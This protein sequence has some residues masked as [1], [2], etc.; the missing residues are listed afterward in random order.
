METLCDEDTETASLDEFPVIT[1]KL[2]DE[3]LGKNTK[4]AFRR[5]RIYLCAKSLLQHSLTMELGAQM[6][7]L[8]YKILMLQFITKVCDVFKAKK[9]CDMSLM[10]QA[11]AKIARRID[12]LKKLMDEE[13]K[14]ETIDGHLNEMFITATHNA[15][16]MIKELRKKVNTQVDKLQSEDEKNAM[17]SPLIALNF[18]E[19]VNQKVKRLRE[20]LDKR[21]TESV[22]SENYPKKGST[23]SR[24]DF[25]HYSSVPDNYFTQNNTIEKN[26]RL[27]D[28][29]NWVLY[30]L[31]L[32]ERRVDADLIRKNAF[33][34]ATVAESTYKN[35]QLAISRMI[36]VRLKL[37]AILDNIACEKFPLLLKYHSGI[38]PNII[39]TLLL[40]QYIDMKIADQLEE[41]FEKR[42][43]IATGPS[44]IEEKKASAD[45]FAAAFAAQ[46]DEMIRSRN[47][48]LNEVERNIK[49]LQS[50]WITA[51]NRVSMLR[52]AMKGQSH[53]RTITRKGTVSCQN[54][55]FC[56][57]KKQVKKA[58]LNQYV[59]RLPEKEYQQ[60]AIIFEQH[61]PDKIA[62]LR[63]VLYNFAEYCSGK[64]EKIK[65]QIEEHTVKA[66]KPWKGRR[67]KARA[68]DLAQDEPETDSVNF[69][70]LFKC[71][72]M[73]RLG[74]T[75]F[76]PKTSLHVDKP[77]E[78]FI[79]ENN[80]D[81]TYHV[82]QHYMP[83]PI[84][85]NSVKSRCTLKAEPGTDFEKLQWM[86]DD[87]S[88]TENQVLAAQSTCPDGLSLSEF[89]SF[90]CLRADGYCLQLRKLYGLIETEALPFEQSSVLSLIMQALWECKEKGEAG[91]ARETYANLNDS[92][93]ASSIIQLLKKFIKQ[94]KDNWV[95]PLKLVM[96]SFIVVRV[97]EINEYDFVA[98]EIAE[99]LAEIRITAID[100]IKKIQEAIRDLK[101]PDQSMEQSLRLKLVLVAFAGAI[102]FSVHPS[103]KFHKKILQ[104][105]PYNNYSAS[106]IWLQFVITL[107]NNILLSQDSEIKS[108]LNM[109]MF[110]RLTQRIGVQLEAG[111]KNLVDDNDLLAIIRNQWKN[112]DESTFQCSYFDSDCPQTYCAEINGKIV[113]IDI[114]TGDFLVNNLPVARLPRKISDDPLYYRV[115]QNFTFEIQ[116]EDANTY[117]T[118]QKYNKCVYKFSC[119]NEGIVITECNQENKNELELLPLN[120][121]VDELP[122]LL[123]ENYSHWW[124]KSKNTIDF[125]PKR[126]KNEK[127]SIE[128]GVEYRLD[129]NE[130]CLTHLRTKRNVLDVTSTS[131]LNIVK[132]LSR[133][134]HS[135]F[136]NIL[137]DISV[138]HA[139]I[140]LPRMNLKFR[141]KIQNDQDKEYDIL[142][143]EFRNMRVSLHQKCGTLFGLNHGL[144]LESANGNHS[145]PKLLLMPHGEV[146]VGRD[147]N[148][149]TVDID[150]SEDLFNP[151]F[152]LYSID[153]TC[154]QLKAV[155]NSYSAWIYLAYL[156]ALTSHGEIEPFTGLSGTENAL[157]ILQSGFVWSST[158]YD[159]E[160]IQ[161]LKDFIE[162]S[163]K[164][165]AGGVLQRVEWPDFIPPH[166][167]QDSY[168]FIAKKLLEDSQRLHQLHFAKDIT[169][170]L[171]TDLNLNKRAYLRHLQSSPN[172]RVAETFI[173]HEPIYTTMPEI[174]NIQLSTRT[175]TI[176]S[177]YYTHG[178][179][180][181]LDSKQCEVDGF[182]LWTFL[183][184]DTKTLLGLAYY[185]ELQNILSHRSI[186]KL[187]NMW[188]SLYEA[189]RRKL[190]S[191]EE[192][193]LIWTLLAHKFQDIRPILTLQA[194]ERNADVFEDIESPE[195]DEYKI[196]EGFY[197]KEKIIEILRKHANVGYFYPMSGKDELITKIA[198][199]IDEAW[200]CDRFESDEV[201]DISYSYLYNFYSAFEEINEK[202]MIW[203]QNEMLKDFIENVK[204]KLM[205]LMPEMTTVHAP[206]LT[207]YY[208]PVAK[209]WKKYEIN[210][211][212]KM[213]RIPNK[214]AKEIKEARLL[215]REQ[216][217]KSKKTSEQW[218]KIY[219]SI[220]NTQIEK[221]YIDAGMQP[222]LVLSFVLP[223]LTSTDIDERL[224][225]I[226]GALA[227]AIA[228]EQRQNRIKA[229]T[230]QEQLKPDLDKEEENQPYINWKPC[231]YPEWLIFEIEQNLTIRRIQIEI[232]KR[233]IQPPKTHDA[234]HSTMQLNMG[235]GKTAVLVPILA[236]VLAN[237][238]QLC[239]IT[240]LKSLFATNVK[241]IRKY[242]GG[243]LNRRIYIFPCRRDLPIADHL[244]R[245]LDI[246]EECKELKGS[247]TLLFYQTIYFKFILNFHSFFRS[248]Y[249]ATRVSAFIPT[250]II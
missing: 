23:Y 55:H 224:K 177:L 12:K 181:P 164:R 129:L 170:E 96:A 54:C 48:M 86:I 83:Q 10:I 194:V 186:D 98:D 203:N 200:P 169:I 175:R 32:K 149:V 236:S 163:P 142:S 52:E 228:Q 49:N 131:Y 70:N 68:V 107:N 93:F 45:S 27:I 248:N 72:H 112:A 26:L 195:V 211:E 134:E 225:M 204:D 25:N 156:H 84:A 88:H 34:Y 138:D 73:V 15:K 97:M 232:A 150:T 165:T 157:Q 133:I 210:F 38:N 79:L 208:K 184:K 202:L 29:E 135:N 56:N 80:F 235:E 85:D 102:T 53:T 238:Q 51:R 162:L 234:K 89:K 219:G 71:S 187:A 36:L 161:L 110:L 59:K 33:S 7:K 168:D 116:P 99:L 39:K 87:T 159:D 81:C 75:K 231:E 6:G 222:R 63:D 147:E 209:K 106:R 57:L 183:T 192:F 245:I 91:S 201:N 31:E 229:L 14:G 66:K 118:L 41:H 247:S 108:F 207:E 139:I 35:D 104:S 213:N 215:W 121:L 119:M 223:K 9:A 62:H 123:V 239:Q 117:T 58:T 226:I 237:G 249:V 95:H 182:D 132:Q 230:N 199:K 8:F 148:H 127:F 2:R 20:Y 69:F 196:K 233:M 16:S 174:E 193:T 47:S 92:S 74:S 44:L 1:K 158:P 241:S 152:H 37:I 122:H 143:N 188:I 242:L 30:Q 160:S 111:M 246:Y 189:A 40:P 197:E 113:K 154:R 205:S 24:H 153:K 50:E 216:P 218:W 13:F 19:D 64:S 155:N 198:H 78:S 126:F 171:G 173:K 166:S 221:Y 240:V 214:F 130:N 180:I 65:L 42:N 67:N 176:S 5:S 128:D 60:N 190:F 103:N 21:Q 61:I 179:N 22:E 250:Q 100:W 172:L 101:N 145:A 46:N 244:D 243:M 212:D 141:I 151:P 167:A 146:D 137:L 136:M 114:V 4:N 105:N 227:I 43:M 77:F 185:D 124:N 28:F 109:P 178:Y 125:R 94:Q 120:V 144:L 217:C 140:E 18:K 191:S 206:E 11:M 220:I 115:F 17:L 82:S 90:G 3:I 76:T